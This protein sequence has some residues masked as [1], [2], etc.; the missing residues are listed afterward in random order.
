MFAMLILHTGKP[1]TDRAIERAARLLGLSKSPNPQEAKQA[2]QLAESHM[3]QAGIVLGVLPAYSPKSAR[4]VRVGYDQISI[5]VNG[6]PHW[7]AHLALVIAS[8]VGFHS[9]NPWEYDENLGQHVLTLLGTRESV[10][11]AKWLFAGACLRIVMLRSKETENPFDNLFSIDRLF[12]L[13]KPAS[14]VPRALPFEDKP[15]LR[16]AFFWGAVMAEAKY[17]RDLKVLIQAREGKDTTD[18]IGDDDDFESVITREAARHRYAQNHARAMVVWQAPEAPTLYEGPPPAHER[19]TSPPSNQE[20]PASPS[21]RHDATAGED[22]RNA[23]RAEIP[24]TTATLEMF[25]RFKED[26]SLSDAYAEGFVSAGQ[27]CADLMLTPRRT[28]PR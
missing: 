1:E 6:V 19:P 25:A 4:V 9:D 23:H 5:L 27:V 17:L 20:G 22:E 21:S 28:I 14:R 24:S 15:V 2:L 16:H 8:F 13:S 18:A 26:P 7:R 10:E 12:N 11:R 3:K